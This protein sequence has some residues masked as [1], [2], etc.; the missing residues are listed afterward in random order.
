MPIVCEVVRIPARHE[1]GVDKPAANYVRESSYAS[2]AAAEKHARRLARGIGVEPAGPWRNVAIQSDR[3][4]FEVSIRSGWTVREDWVAKDTHDGRVNTTYKDF[5][6]RE[7]AETY[8]VDRNRHYVKGWDGPRWQQYVHH[9]PN[10]LA[11]L[12]LQG[13]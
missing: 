9:T 7:E 5:S 1:N 6:S 2:D 4:Y 13:R 8:M 3:G 10:G 11:T 12:V